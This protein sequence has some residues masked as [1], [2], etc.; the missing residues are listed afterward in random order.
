MATYFVDYV[1]GSN[2][3]SGATGAPWQTPAKALLVVTNG[4]TVKFRG[5]SSNSASWY[6][7]PWT[8]RV[9]G[10]TWT[11]DTGHTPTFDG[12]YNRSGSAYNLGNSRPGSLYNAFL[13][14]R[15]ANTT[16]SGLR[17]QNVGGVGIVATREAD[18]AVITNCTVDM[19]YGSSLVVNASVNAKVADV[20]ISYCT[21]TNS[22]YALK[23]DDVPNT[24][25]QQKAG[26]A[27]MLRE[28]TDLHFH[29]NTVAYS[30]KEGVNVDKGGE[31]TIIEYNTIHSINH[32]AIYINRTVECDIRFNK[33]YHTKNKEFLGASYK[34]KSAPPAIKIGDELGANQNS[35]Y[36]NSSKQRIYGNLV[37]GGANCIIVS[38]NNDPHG[39]DTQLSECY[40]GFNTFVG[41]T[42]QS[43][44]GTAST[45]QVVLI[46]ANQWLR[47]HQKT[48]FENNIIYAPTGVKLAEVAG[49]AGVTFR[50]NCWYSVDG[51]AAPAAVRS[52]GD[53]TAQPLLVRPTAPIV[54]VWPSLTGSGFDVDNYRLNK[55]SPCI[56][57][58]SDMSRTNSLTPPTITTDL[59]GGTRNNLDAS[60]NQ[61]FD[62]GALEYGASDGGGGVTHYLTANFTQSHTT[63]EMPLEVTFTNTSTEHGSANID[64][65][66]WEFG[67]GN[68]STSTDTTIVYSYPYSGR[69]TPK[70]TVK[71][72]TRNLTSVDTGSQI[73]V[74]TPRQGDIPGVMDIVRTTMPTAVGNKTLLFSLNNHV[75]ALVLFFLSKATVVGTQADG[76]MLSY[77]A[78]TPNGQWC[79]TF[80]SRDAQAVTDTHKRASY[81]T[82][83]QALHNGETAGLANAKSFRENRVILEITEGFTDG[84]ILTA[85]AFAGAQYAGKAD[86]FWLGVQNQ[87]TTLAP[88]FRPELYMF[89]G[90]VTQANGA[91]E[92]NADF[93]IGFADGNGGEYSFTWRD[94][95]GEDTTRTK[96][97][98]SNG[99]RSI[100]QPIN[101]GT[102]AFDNYEL[103]K[104]MVHGKDINRRFGY[105]ALDVPATTTIKTANFSTPTS[106]GNQSYNLGIQP[107][108]LILLVSSLAKYSAFDTTAASEGFAII[109]ADQYATYGTAIASTALA[110]TSNTKSLAT[111]NVKVINGAG[112]TILEG[113]LTLDATGFDINWTT[114]Q[115]T[116]RHFIAMGISGQAAIAGP[117]P[118]FTAD[119]T[120]PVNG[121]VQFTDTSN[122][123]GSA[124]TDW[125]WEF[126][127]GRDSD[128]QHPEHTYD[129]S[130]VYTVSLTVTNANGEET[131]TKT[132]YIKVQVAED[133]LGTFWPK[134][135]TNTSINVLYGDDETN[136]Y[137][138]DVEHELDLDALEIDEDP[139]DMTSASDKPGKTRIV[140]DKDN[141][142]LKIIYNDGTVDY[143][144]FD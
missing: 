43:P 37:V 63:G 100:R 85:V 66:L 138:G 53:V 107:T 68:T 9:A 25:A 126:G 49:V 14:I 11:N 26:N 45:D 5:S 44:I 82:C 15:A 23:A 97:S 47:P 118:D 54:D 17:F 96:A 31:R 98:I 75:P 77:G 134:S 121:V 128:E 3:N 129:Q 72:T 73:K 24:G 137:Y 111:N 79:Y 8:I 18:D 124:I 46:N 69:Y 123:N 86:D 115:S 141:G 70:L 42:W 139:D 132:N 22:S 88:G 104:I 131:R 94:S 74:D 92:D 84:Y 36:D 102:A 67:D 81:S 2:N 78:A 20:E 41:E 34:K 12:D 4:D 64:A 87:V 62:L 30:Y 117:I 89:G 135:V 143:I 57:A 113:T 50:N 59:V 130:G 103:A 114:V 83:V 125:L 29:H 32:S 21:F 52:P 140:M 55:N 38:N 10:V 19:T 90:N 13:T 116:P 101:A 65:V 58:A 80:N 33:V 95:N 39:Y 1:N 71:D 106:T 6:P 40:I 60:I 119:T 28:C 136:P 109:A 127:D 110:A 35:T 48:I 144:S 56:G 7:D 105:A 76:A 120:T 61:Y 93:C 133:W 122:P 142:R 99:T 108:G 27:V 112:T 51:D 91:V 16:V